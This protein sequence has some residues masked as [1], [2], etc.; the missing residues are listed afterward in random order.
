MRVFRFIVIGIFLTE[1]ICISQN[2]IN[3]SSFDDYY[4]YYDV[5]NNLV[6]H[7]TDWYY[8]DSIL[9]H[10][11]YFSTDRYL[12]KSFG[13]NI[14]PDSL[15]INR[16]EI[17]NY[18]SI[19]ILPNVHRAYTELK[20][21]LMKGIKYYISIDIKAFDQS[22]YFSD[23]LIGFKDSVDNEMDSCLYQLCLNIPDKF[24]NEMLYDNW[25]TLDTEFIATGQEKILVI[26]SGKVRDYKRIIY[27]N[28]DKY[29]IMKYQGPPKLKYFIDNIILTEIVN[30][31]D[32]KYT[33]KFDSL[34]V[35]DE[36]I[37]NNIY[38][39]FDKYELRNIS[40][41]ELDRVCTYM[42]KNEKITIQV[43]GHTDDFGSDEY[44]DE[45]SLN[46]ATAVMDY[47]V[48]KG[49]SQ[50]RII[51]KGLGEKYPICTNNTSVGRQ[52]NRRIEMKILQK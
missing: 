17:A 3:N 51:V 8:V 25:I 40:F 7:P 42:N 30:N 31:Q 41:K 45:L 34:E 26:S 18:I 33:E 39:D 48:Q 11:I 14:H 50:D 16:G 36:I 24:C 13:W 32:K 46:R 9:N 52:N 10:P 22:N 28:Q 21:S 44:N 19:L 15:L 29:L 23:L 47:L 5:N 38:F 35:G 49:M 2:L 20:S 4:N 37:L 6:Y 1:S 43:S 27:S 12:N